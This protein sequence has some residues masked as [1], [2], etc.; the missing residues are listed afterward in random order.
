[1]F[2]LFFLVGD[3]MNSWLMEEA[4]RCIFDFQKLY[5]EDN[6]ISKKRFD[7]FLDQ[8]K[9]IFSCI[10]SSINDKL[11][12]KMV[13]LS[14]MGYEL[15]CKKNKKYVD[16]HLLIEKEY[17]DHLFDEIDS[18]I[19]LDEEQ[20]KAI[21]ID[22]DYSLIIAGAG[23][24]KTTTMAA[25][26]KYLIEKKDISPKKIILL[27][28]TKKSTDDLNH[29]LNEQFNLNV[30]VLTFHKLGLNF[31]R[32]IY[33]RRPKIVGEGGL[34]TI[35]SNYFVNIVFK[36]KL[37][38][39]QYLT[40]FNEYL[41]IDKSAIDF[42]SYQEYYSHYMDLR[43]EKVKNNL[44]EEIEKLIKHRVKI[45]RTINGEMVKSEGEVN[46]ANY[47]YLNSI[48]YQY[49][50]PYYF[51]LPN[52][53]VYQPD[54]T[55]LNEEI[56]IEYFGLATLKKDGSYISEIEKYQ[57]EIGMKRRTHLM[58][59]TDLVEIY[60]NY[61]EDCDIFS[62]LDKELDKRKVV[63]KKKTEK[64]IFYRLMET[65][66][67][68]PYY[69]LINVVG[70]FIHYFKEMNYCVDDFKRLIENTDNSKL[71][72]QLYLICDMY[73]YYQN[74]LYEENC[75][76]F[77]DM[78][79]MAYERMDEIKEKRKW[80][81][82]DYVIVD[83]YQDISTPRYNFL[84]KI[85]DLFQAKIVAVGDDWQAIYS[86]SGS[87]I[88][89]F[90][91]FYELM[92]YAEIVKIT[93]T[94]RNSQELIDLAGKFIAKNPL[95]IEKKLKSNKRLEKPVELVAYDYGEI[96]SN[97]PEMVDKLI[98]RIYFN[99]P[100]HRILLL[101]RFNSE[102]D[103]LLDSKYFYRKFKKDDRIIC[104][105]TPKASIEFLTVH[106]S[107]G[108]GYDQVILLNSLNAVKGFPSQMKDDP[109]LAYLK[110]QKESD[111]KIEYP[112]ERRLFYVAMTR[113]KNKLYIMYPRN[114]ENR[115]I[116][117]K[118]IEDDINVKVNI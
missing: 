50:K 32:N 17:F 91:K 112:E 6:Y 65:S 1:M 27:S 107:K 100:N 92:G 117:I 62:I 97:L 98:K 63:R 52:G 38:L 28:F 69:K 66:S 33:N 34:L 59:E 78:I 49:E 48:D 57:K 71:K 2:L 53:R 67:I 105:S 22:E 87:D 70:N 16:R 101:G 110:S 47:L 114:M 58:Y 29:L 11:M 99:N 30:E 96:D 56:Y 24:G 39:N 83:E 88:D 90:T 12:Q 55:I 4:E 20:R 74:Q 51:P 45:G 61:E 102:V 60:G 25:K 54:F 40:Y 8:Y 46:I 77:Q 108:L 42:S 113:T 81:K 9:D 31:L 82:Y 19:L 41:I 13:Y 36:D 64:E 109:L 72:Q 35:L 80:I 116:F 118:E 14:Q 95:Q 73:N 79:H 115:S 68:Y 106:K 75:I 89:L 10:D 37:L 111:E 21:L 26:V 7:L 84:K 94:Y 43:Y 93:N 103:E 76:D 23:S 5:A 85:S 18:N 44:N 86:F 15:I 3:F 104:C